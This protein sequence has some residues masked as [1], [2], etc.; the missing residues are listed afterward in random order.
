[1]WIYRLGFR[2]FRTACEW[3]SR[4]SYHCHCPVL[5]SFAGVRPLEL[6]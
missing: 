3:P 1:M 2:W 4:N 6:L 5:A